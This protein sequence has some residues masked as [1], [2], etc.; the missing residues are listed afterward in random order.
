MTLDAD[1]RRGVESPAAP[2]RRRTF[3]DI[4]RSR[5]GS[6]ALTITLDVLALSVAVVVPDFWGTT[7]LEHDDWLVWLF[8]PV[9]LLAFTHD[10][11]YRRNLT[12]DFLDEVYP[13][14]SSIAIASFVMLGILLLANNTHPGFHVIWTGVCAA[15]LVQLV[16]LVRNWAQRSFR[17]AQKSAG[18]TLIIGNTQVVDRLIA[19]MRSFPEYGLRPVGIMA[20][21]PPNRSVES[22]TGPPVPY[23]G[24]PGEFVEVAKSMGVEEVV[25]TK[26]DTS[27]DELVDLI[28][29]AHRH[30]IR[31]W[32]VP[33]LQDAV[34]KRARI[35]H[36]GGVPLL[37]LPPVNPSG[38]QFAIKY[39]TDRIGAALA[40]LLISPLFLTLA[41]LVKLSSPG[42]IFYRQRRVGRDGKPFD[43]LKFRSM[44]EASDPGTAFQPKPGTAPGGVEGE[45][46]RTLV[47]KVMRMLSLDE[48][49]Q[50]INV[51]RGDMSLVGPRPERPEFV[52]LF[53]MQI[54]RYGQRHR[55]KAG[56]TGWAQVHGLRGQ[57]SIADRAEWDNY[58]IE[59]RSFWLD[60]KILLLTVIAVFKHAE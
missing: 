36:L 46:R 15:I 19:R 17:R 56:L 11:L 6:V 14:L 32:V 9:V 31:V 51:L 27:D 48:L 39:A 26:C 42:P 21:T 33:R 40:L 60:I 57:T 12:R 20:S 2:T 44:R 53:E 37:V 1:P 8:V 10:G 18:P 5:V 58:Y 23:V 25:I 55:V 16:R 59:N 49:P 52:E 30:D 4:A 50:L 47:G 43:C 38:W 3:F 13:I 24:T 35:D 45:D 34:G 29:K 41:L 7:H 22:T 28:G 54:H